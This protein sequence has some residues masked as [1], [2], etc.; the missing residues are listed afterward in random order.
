MATE[1]GLGNPGLLRQIITET[2][3]DAVNS[4]L[5]STLGF[6]NSVRNS[7]APYTP[8]NDGG[9]YDE[10]GDWQPYLCYGDVWDG[11]VPC[12]PD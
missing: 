4:Q 6:Q 11:T 10:F 5:Q 3:T 2:V 8:P 7:G 1:R 12:A 9:Y